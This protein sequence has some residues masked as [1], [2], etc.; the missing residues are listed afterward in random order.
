[1][2]A[3][4]AKAR[5]PH[6]EHSS[7]NVPV[8]VHLPQRQEARHEQGQAVPENLRGDCADVCMH[9]AAMVGVRQDARGAQLR[10]PPRGL[11]E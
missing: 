10:H 3:Y 6:R 8:P 2:H 9:H 4:Q 5:R 1:M 7:E 11:G